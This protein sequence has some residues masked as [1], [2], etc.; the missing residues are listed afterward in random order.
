MDLREYKKNIKKELLKFNCVSHCWA[1]GHTNDLY[2]IVFDEKRDTSSFY[3]FL[4][5]NKDRFTFKK[6]KEYGEE[7][8]F[9]TLVNLDK[10]TQKSELDL[11]I[12]DLENKLKEL[13]EKRNKESLR[14]EKLVKINKLKE[15]IKKLEEGL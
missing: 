10:F 6:S 7:R 15:Q 5:N 11:E 1:W 12:E 8:V 13:K 2:C 4:L 3:E 14:N 9:I